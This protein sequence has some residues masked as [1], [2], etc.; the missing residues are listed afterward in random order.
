MLNY[1]NQKDWP[2]LSGQMQ[3]PVNLPLATAQHHPNPSLAPLMI[4]CEA[5]VQ[6]VFS[7]DSSL[8]F[9]LSGQNLINGRQFYL[10]QG[11]I[12]T[13]SEHSFDHRFFAAELHLVH[14]ASDGRLAVIAVM[15][16][17]G[18][19]NPALAMILQH[20]PTQTAFQADLS[21]L[22]P[23]D[24]HFLHYL[25][26]LTTPPLTENVEWYLFTQPVTGSASQLDQLA[27][28]HPNNHR[29]QQALNNRPVEYV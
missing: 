28:F 26:S 25:G 29:Q 5:T 16:E 13:P 19:A 9:G 3:S 7:S 22:L 23:T 6:T 8:T 1:Q 15:L 24:G 10:Q 12:H 11:H 2:F 27:A 20:Y 14:Q 17:K 4:K 18:A 21:A